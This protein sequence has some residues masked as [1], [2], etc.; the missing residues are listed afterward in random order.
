MVNFSHLGRLYG[1]AKTLG[2]NLPD[3]CRWFWSYYASRLPGAG[4]RATS[5]VEIDVRTGASNALRLR[6]RN[7]GFDYDVVE[8]IFARNAYKMDL[9]NVSRVLDLGGNI[10]LASLFFARSYPGAQICTVEP[11]PGNL[12]ILESNLKLNHVPGRVVPG[13]VGER[14]GKIRFVLSQDPTQH[15]SE[16][17]GIVGMATGNGIEVDMVS[18]PSL[19]KLMGWAEIDLLKIDI[20][21]GETAVLGGRPDWLKKVRVIIG[22]GHVGV[23]YTIEACRT[24]LEPMGFQVRLLDQRPGAMLFLAH[25]HDG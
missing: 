21:G 2:L 15:S 10:G 16:A 1:S 9:E 19:M 14:D 6:I 13:A 20:E 4:S 18:V 5:C 23:G 7:N 24:D 22:E 25:R 17:T 11:I 12:A 3:T 8:E